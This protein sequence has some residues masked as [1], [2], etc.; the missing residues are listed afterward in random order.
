[1]NE[2]NILVDE[3]L[4][5]V[6]DVDS[7]SDPVPDPVQVEVEVLDEYSVENP[8]PVM[9]VEE[10]PVQEELQVYSL[11]GSYNGTISD[12]YLSYFEGIVQKLDY[13]DNYVIWRSGAYAYSMAY[14]EEIVLNGSVFS[15]PC[16]LVEI[17]RSSDSYNS[18]WYV[19][20]SLD[21]L[22]VDATTLFL[23][24]N[25]GMYPTVERGFSTYESGTLVFVAV[26]MFLC[27]VINGIFKSVR[28]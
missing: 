15:G 10:D 16:N 3:Q 12:T 19:S 20:S 4:D 6:T 9:L 18:D 2:D 5:T 17:Y 24:S 22:N 1:M 26:L 28:S 8:L 11:S 23:Y 25:L 27:C 21:E 7:L 13:N 14:G